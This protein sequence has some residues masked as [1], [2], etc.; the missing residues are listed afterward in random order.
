MVTVIIVERFLQRTQDNELLHLFHSLL[1]LLWFS[2][3]S[4]LS[5]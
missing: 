2:V 5:T 1:V 4:V 3:W